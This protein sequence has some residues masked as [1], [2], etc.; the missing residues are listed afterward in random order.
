M[1][2]FGLVSRTSIR[3]GMVGKVFF[4]LAIVASILVVATPA[5]AD[6]RNNGV[7]FHR[8]GYDYGPSII[9]QGTIRQYWWCG[10]GQNP[11]TGIYTDNIFYRS[12]DSSTGQYSPI[13]LVLSPSPGPNVWDEAYTCDPSVIKG[14]FVNPANGQTYAYAMYYTATDRGPGGIDTGGP[15]DGTNNRIGL[16]Y[17]NDGISWVKYANNPV[18]YPQNSPSDTYAAG[19]AATYSYDGKAGIYVFHT[20]C[21]NTTLGCRLWSRKAS[22]GIHFGA[23]TLISNQGL[24]PNQQPQM[25]NNDVAIDWQE[26]QVYGALELPQRSGDRETYEIGLYRMS[27]SDFFNGQ[28]TWQTLGRIDTNLTGSYLNHSPG[29]V[30]DQ[31]GNVTPFLPSIE[32]AFAEGTNDP[33]TWDLSSVTWNP[34]PNTLAFNRYYKSGV[35]HWVTTGYVAAGYNLE[36]TLGYLFMAPQSNTQALYSCV[37]GGFSG[38]DHFVSPDPAC[39]GQF[40]LGVNGWIYSSQPAGVATVALYR[41]YTGVDHFV[42][43]Y[44][45]CEGQRVESLLGYAK[46]QP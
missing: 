38:T 11:A 40:V 27:S 43:P 4:A 1:S 18:I 14:Q 20:D 45:N 12:Y 3:W 5:R 19:Q 36:S 8:D 32:V 30:R 26:G 41:C 25:G 10:E 24:L 2:R 22:D 44:A 46:T 6:Y 13:S 21:S 7:L 28:G 15:L 17:S 37:A 29:I 33:N 9:Q 34:T 42:S 31:F 35:S 16:A 39:E 23:P